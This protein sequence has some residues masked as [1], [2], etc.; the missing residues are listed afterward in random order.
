MC[1]KKKEILSAVAQLNRVRYSLR[2]KDINFFNVHAIVRT[3]DQNGT[4]EL[5][6]DMVYLL[7]CKQHIQFDPAKLEPLLKFVGI[8]DE[9]S[10]QMKY[11]EFIDMLNILKPY[12]ILDK[13]QDVPQEHL[14]YTS[15]YAALLEDAKK[16]FVKNVRQEPSVHPC[17]RTN[18]AT[19]LAPNECIRNG[20]F[21]ND[22]LVGRS[23]DVIR[24]I[25]H[26][27]GLY[28]MTDEEFDAAFTECCR[29]DEARGGYDM[30]G[31]V[32]VETFKNYLD[33]K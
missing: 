12:P 8:V 14:H 15:T 7:L 31:L 1:P 5:H 29:R 13:I 20:L 27:S 28:Q 30:A 4:H 3:F 19:L 26:T 22:Y 10:G 17:D 24:A 6:K 32:C 25:F 23:R 2:K 18:V 33:S 21:H 9:A 11:D 16:P